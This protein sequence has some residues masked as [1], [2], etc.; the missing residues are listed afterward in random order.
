MQIQ[1]LL[2]VLVISTVNYSSF[3]DVCDCPISTYKFM[4]YCK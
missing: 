1:Q 2:Y 3:I 4:V